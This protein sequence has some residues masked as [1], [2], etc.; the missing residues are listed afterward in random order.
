[1][2]CAVL[3]ACLL[4]CSGADEQAEQSAGGTGG[5]AIDSGAGAGGGGSGGTGATSTGGTGGVAADAGNAGDSG[6]ALVDPDS[7]EPCTEDPDPA[8]WSEESVSLLAVGATSAYAGAAVDGGVT[9]LVARILTNQPSAPTGGAVYATVATGGTWT[10]PTQLS[11]TPDFL[12]RPLV[13]VASDGSGG[14]A[15]WVEA[16]D[17]V[18][19]A[20]WSAGA[21]WAPSQPLPGGSG[22]DFSSID[23]VALPGGQHILATGG[24][25]LILDSNGTQTAEV[26]LPGGL[27]REMFLGADDLPVVYMTS[28]L[29]AEGTSRY[30][31]APGAG[32]GPA[33]VA[34]LTTVQAPGWQEFWFEAASGI[35]AR[36]IRVGGAQAGLYVTV[37]RGPAS[38]SVEERITTFAGDT[39]APTVTAA[40][41]DLVVLWPE[42]GRIAE[43]AHDGAWSAQRPLARSSN[44]EL[45][46]IAGSAIGAG[47]VGTITLDGRTVTKIFRRGSDGG[48]YCP[49]LVRHG[50]NPTVTSDPGGELL[51]VGNEAGDVRLVRFRP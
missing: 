14:I 45:S 21:G 36:L 41:G 24:S 29:I 28:V 42:G 2:V 9:L 50:L 16:D 12:D 38:Y 6:A 40:G 25:L 4:A 30:V 43:R 37:R 13:R 18:R 5:G 32:L 15:L 35:G 31:Y 8:G 1:L 26:T 3:G 19:Y 23:A 48:W 39:S 22:L 33:E 44:V 27:H 47:L 51:F 7:D 10:E 20:T 46:A 11:A 34:P 17:T 49:R